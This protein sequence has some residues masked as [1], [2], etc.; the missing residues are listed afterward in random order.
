[1]LPSGGSSFGGESRRRNPDLIR[2]EESASGF[3]PFPD[4][5]PGRRLRTGAGL[6]QS[7]GAGAAGEVF[8]VPVAGMNIR[9][10]EAT[11]IDPAFRQLSQALAAY[12]QATLG[13]GLDRQLVTFTD[14]EFGR[15]MTP[16]HLHGSNAGSG[17]HQIVVGGGVKGGEV[18]GAFPQI[19]APAL[20]SDG[21]L[22]PTTARKLPWRAGKLDGSCVQ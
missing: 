12:Y 22:I 19:S 3:V 14:S 4:T 20:D 10:H 1:M 8:F 21:S 6:I 16:N 2:F 13:L 15:A 5:P 7:G 18:Y 9:T 11:R 17:N